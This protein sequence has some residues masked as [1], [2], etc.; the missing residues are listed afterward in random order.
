MTEKHPRFTMPPGTESAAETN[1]EF[2]QEGPVSTSTPGEAVS[3]LQ[4]PYL[5]DYMPEPQP[6]SYPVTD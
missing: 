4:D 2:E 1:L 5:G 6:K 3:T